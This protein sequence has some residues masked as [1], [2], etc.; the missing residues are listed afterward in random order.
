[1]LTV[2]QLY[3]VGFVNGMLTVFFDVA[4]QS[5]LPSLVDRDQ[6]VEGNSKLEISRT[7]AQTAGPASAAASS[8][9]SPHRSRSWPTAQLRRVGRSSCS[10]SASTSRHPD[11]TSTSTARH[12]GASHEVADGLRYVLGNRYLRHIAGCTATSNLFGNIAFATILVYLVRELGLEPATIGIVFGIGN[13]GA[14]VGAFTADRIAARLGVGPT[15]DRVAVHRRTGAAA[16]RRRA[17]KEAADPV[18]HR[19]GPARRAS[20]RSST[21]STRSASARPS[22][23]SGCRAG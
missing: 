21:T 19:V 18:P 12:A 8:S 23:P 22:P 1:M 9:W 7:I 5:Y 10:A 15:I 20:R 4:Y 14:I 16:R 3:V 6:L 17:P 13:V 11:A 2:G